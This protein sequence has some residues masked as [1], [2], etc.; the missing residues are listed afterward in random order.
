M[1]DDILLGRCAVLPLHPISH[2]SQFCAASQG[3]TEDIVF[4]LKNSKLP[5][6]SAS[7]SASKPHLVKVKVS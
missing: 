6:K 7:R 2:G 5:K 3:W 1:V 4:N